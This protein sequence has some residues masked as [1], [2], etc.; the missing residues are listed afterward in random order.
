MEFSKKR[1]IQISV[2][3]AILC[4]TLFVVGYGTGRYAVPA[5]IV[6]VEKEKIVTVEKQVIVTQTKTEIK[7][8]TVK[9]T[10]V[11]VHRVTTDVHK[12]DGT[13]TTIVV[14]DDH[15]NT[16]EGTGTNT[17]S[18][19]NTHVTDNHSTVTE[20][21][22]VK[23][24]TNAAPKWYFDVNAGWALNSNFSPSPVWGVGVSRRI[25]GPIWIGVWGNTQRLAGVGVGL[26]F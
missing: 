4:A 26:G 7:V 24:I 21:E 13:T 11:N 12:P 19:N 20:K 23:T 22:T 25:V 14:E 3:S 9:D 8:V 16:H 10:R 1:I 2:I 18:V 6:T 5:K 15:T 17:N